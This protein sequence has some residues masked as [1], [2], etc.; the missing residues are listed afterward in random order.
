MEK[1]KIDKWDAIVV[2]DEEANVYIIAYDG[3]LGAIVS[4][5]VLEEAE[6][7]FIEGMRLGETVQKL[8]HFKEHGYF[9]SEN[10]TNLNND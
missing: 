7:K 6:K 3:S 8:L 10:K 9:P 2:F 1:R 5:E 4:H